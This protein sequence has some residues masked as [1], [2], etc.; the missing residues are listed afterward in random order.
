M[1]LSRKNAAMSA[2]IM[3]HDSKR[4]RALM[5]ARNVADQMNA[6][7]GDSAASKKHQWL[8]EFGAVAKSPTAP[9]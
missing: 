1:T 4:T 6:P 3:R 2:A 7:Q 9:N 8:N 5:I